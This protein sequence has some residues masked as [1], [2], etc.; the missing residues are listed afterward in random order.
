MHRPDAASAR[1]ALH[2]PSRLLLKSA[3]RASSWQ[4]SGRA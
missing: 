3:S 1:G 4:E 2:I